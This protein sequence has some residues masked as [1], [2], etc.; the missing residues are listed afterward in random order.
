MLI[1]TSVCKW[2]FDILIFHFIMLEFDTHLWDTAGMVQVVDSCRPCGKSRL[3][4]QLWPH[5]GYNMHL[6][7]MDQLTFSQLK[8]NNNLKSMCL[9]S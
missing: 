4:S 3:S 6:G 8:N 7:R 5:L 2:A 1:Y 9:S